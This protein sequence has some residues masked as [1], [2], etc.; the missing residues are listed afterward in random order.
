MKGVNQFNPNTDFVN[1]WSLSADHIMDEVPDPHELYGKDIPLSTARGNLTYLQFIDLLKA[2]WSKANPEVEF[3]PMGNR[4]AFKPEKGYIVYSLESKKA[5]SD[6]L[7][8]R[9]MEDVISTD[10]EE[11]QGTIYIQKFDYLLEFSAVHKEPRT[12]EEILDAF[13]DFMMIITPEL[14]YSG[15]QDL[16]YNR[17]ITDRDQS[18]F[19]GDVAYRTVMYLVML[20]KMLV[21]KR[22]ILESVRLD[23]RTVTNR[24]VGMAFDDE[25]TQV[26]FADLYRTAPISTEE[27]E[28][29][30]DESGD[31]IE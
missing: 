17:R 4:E 20:Q 22:Q 19:G 15:V 25:Y 7:K 8:P 14:K 3:V 26:L 11:F 2:L 31:A 5:A 28:V 12:A 27:S 24:C 6:N 30:L 9:F 13:E 23:V 1:R 21:A 16:Y 18:R 10:K 29:L